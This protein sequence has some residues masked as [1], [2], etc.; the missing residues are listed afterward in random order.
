M[1]A[2]LS[3]LRWRLSTRLSN[4]TRRAQPSENH[5]LFA[6]LRWAKRPLHGGEMNGGFAIRNAGNTF[7]PTVAIVDKALK[8]N[9]ARAAFGKPPP[10]CPSPMGKKTPPRRGNE[11]RLRSPQCGQHFRPYGGDCRQGFQIKLGARGLRKNTAK[12]VS[13]IYSIIGLPFQNGYG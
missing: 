12:C 7:A 2:T 5:P 4:Q 1:R 3:P 6:H 9:S 8:S 10:F 13:C 11:R